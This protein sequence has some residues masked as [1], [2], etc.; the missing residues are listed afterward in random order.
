MSLHHPIGRPRPRLCRPRLE[1]LEDRLAPATITVMTLA[2]SGPGSLRQAIGDAN[3]MAGDDVIQFAPGLHGTISLQSAL[4]DLISNV[5]VQGPGAS[6]LSV[7]I[8]FASASGSFRLFTVTPTATVT[9]SGLTLTG[10]RPTLSSGGG[11]S[12]AGDLTLRDSVVID[13]RLDF[14]DGVISNSGTL[15]VTSST[16]ANN[17]AAFG[18][19]GGIQN[20][21]TLIVSN[22]TISGNQSVNP[23]G[24]SFGG[25]AA[26]AG[27][28]N[29]GTLTLTSSTVTGNSAS[30]G[31]GPTFG[32]GAGVW[33]DGGTATLRNSIVA[34]NGV[35]GFPV[36]VGPFFGQDVLGS[37][38]SLG[39]NL[40][41]DGTGATGFGAA[42]DRVG[43]GLGPI[44]AE[45]GPLQDNGGPTPTQAPLAGS[46]AIDGGDPASFPGTDQRGFPRPTDGEGDGTPRPDVG[47]V[48]AAAGTSR[49]FA[50]VVAALYRDLLGRR[51]DP[52]GEAHWVGLLQNG[53]SPQVVAL[54]IVGSQEYREHVIDGLYLSLLN[55]EADPAG[56]AAFAGQLA[57]GATTAR[58]EAALLGSPEYSQMHGSNDAYLQ[59][60]Y[61][62]VLQRSIDP[63]GQASGNALLAAGISRASVALILLQS[64]EARTVLVQNDYQAYLRRAADPGGQAGFVAALLAGAR[65]DA[66]TLAMTGSTEFAGLFPS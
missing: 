60:L 7:Q 31:R 53:A 25:F 6:Q 20:T 24:T 36:F 30:P 58:V 26:A 8:D 50:T 55:R 47:A 28:H 45:L 17:L 35:T 39:H 46:L 21:G 42:G 59:A 2:D 22:S 66:V 48:E 52:T 29:Q 44:N 63:S 41:G 12:N 18:G 15:T 10:G 13:T 64:A 54:G 62:T 57:Q 14:T 32:L 11:I 1:A 37:F 5:A 33:N 49:R 23:I 56:L 38:T 4:P 51:V 34:Q 19:V 61:Q 65:E 40:I 43:T 9:L 27:I 16:I 3:S